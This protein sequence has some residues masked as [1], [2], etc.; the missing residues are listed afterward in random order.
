MPTGVD[1]FINFKR[2]QIFSSLIKM[3]HWH[4]IFC[5]AL[6]RSR[7]SKRQSQTFWLLFLQAFT[8][9]ILTLIPCVLSLRKTRRL[10]KLI[11]ISSHLR[12]PFADLRQ[13]QISP[14]QTYDVYITS[15]QRRCT[16]MTLD[17][18][19]GNVFINVM[20]LLGRCYER[21]WEHIHMVDFPAFFFTNF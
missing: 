14:Q 9:F 7:S 16:V 17:R 8:H 5:N 2:F 13:K 1:K 20:R 19:W 15:A 18:R 12:T 21:D 10:G 4:E 3:H 11:P 6:K